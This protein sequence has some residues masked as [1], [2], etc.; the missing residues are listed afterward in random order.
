[1]R[2]IPFVLFLSLCIITIG[3]SACTETSYRLPY[4]NG[5]EVEITADHKTHTT[6][7]AEMFDLRGTMPEQTL[8]AAKS[9]WVRHV[10]ESGDSSASTNNFV[11]I[12]HPLDYCQPAGSAPPGS[13]GI[14]QPC[15]TCPEGLGRC[16]EW[17]LYA[18]MKQ[19]SV[20]P[21]EGDWVAEGQ[22]IGI[23]S[24]VGFTPG[25]RHVHFAIWT[26]EKETSTA[27]PDANGTYEDYIAHATQFLGLEG[28]PELVPLFCTSQGLRYPRQGD[29]H[30]AA[31]CP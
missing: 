9:G 7:E 20:G 12:E 27:V 29:V 22:P 2:F 23:E 6:P 18:H 1:M 4:A 24:D 25:G 15:R 5:T 13:G 14:A 30:V 28:R 11:W 16:N 26:F 21:E 10:K 19:N 17:T 3:L 8:V 31:N